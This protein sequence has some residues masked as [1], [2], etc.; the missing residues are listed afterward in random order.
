VS[1]VVTTENLVISPATILSA[2][3]KASTG[4]ALIEKD[5]VTYITSNATDIQD[6]IDNIGSVIDQIV[7]SLTALDAATIPPG[8]A[9]IPIA[10][11][12]TL[13]ATLMAQKELL[14]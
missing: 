9:A 14:K 5:K 1:G 6:L 10:L 7:T 4:A 3:V 12:N 2:G 8:T 13:K 11:I